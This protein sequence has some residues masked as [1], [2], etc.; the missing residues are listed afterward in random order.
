V[1]RRPATLASLAAALAIAI[2]ACGS[3]QRQTPI[4]CL[5]G[6]A[7]YLDA[8]ESAP[9]AVLLEGET[10]I[11]DCL[12]PDQEVGP[13]NTVGSA[14]VEAATKL[15][16]EALRKDGGDA[17][18]QVGYLIGAVQEGASETGGIHTDLVRRLDAAARFSPD[19]EPLSASIE[20]DLGVGYAAGQ[21][22]G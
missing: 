15:N 6:A 1:R 12:V 16:G 22:S 17:A 11:S 5:E 20:R 8:L 18:I 3:D 7:A 21:E 19:G 10:P 4:A 14:V 13:Q 2:A 9:G